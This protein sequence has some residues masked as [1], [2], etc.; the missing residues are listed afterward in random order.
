MAQ[1]ITESN[2]WDT[3][4]FLLFLKVRH[5]LVLNNILLYYVHCNNINILSQQNISTKALG[6]YP[7][8]RKA[9]CFPHQLYR[10]LAPKIPDQ[11][12]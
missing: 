3:H 2:P 10:E 9:K 4:N 11:T 6:N 8:L 12:M 7:T 1:H 5:L